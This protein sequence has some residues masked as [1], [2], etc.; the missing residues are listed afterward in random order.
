MN[1][2]NTVEKPQTVSEKIAEIR[3]KI[4]EIVGE[5]NLEEGMTVHDE[6]TVR[7]TLSGVQ[8]FG[9]LRG[10][11]KKAVIGESGE[12]DLELVQ[13]IIE[14]EDAFEVF[15]KKVE[16]PKQVEEAVTA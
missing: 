10:K 13:S 7:F 2:E 9:Y 5:L 1:T 14:R 6:R 4:K 11:N 8:Y 16:A 12:D 15:A 3:A